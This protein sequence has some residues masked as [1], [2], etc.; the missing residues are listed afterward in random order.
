MKLSTQ[1]ASLFFE[2]MLA[3]QFFVNQRLKVLPSIK[4][5]EEYTERSTEEKFKVREVLYKNP[6]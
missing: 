5:L 1:E 2:L 6:Q 3:L 4:K